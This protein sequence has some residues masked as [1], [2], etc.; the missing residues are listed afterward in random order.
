MKKSEFKYLDLTLYEDVLDNGLKVYIVPKNTVNNIYVTFTTKFGSNILEFMPFDSDKMIKVP[1]GIAHFLEHKTFEQKDGVDPFTFYTKNGADA[2]AYTNSKQTTYLFSGAD[3]FS[4]NLNYLLDYVQA[5]YYTDENV[6]KEKGIIEQELKMYE[7]NPYRSM[8]HDICKN[9][10]TTYSFQTPTIGTLE[11]IYS[12]TKEDLYKCYNTFYNPSNM[13]IVITG[14]VDP[15]ATIEIIKENQKNKVFK[16]NNSKIKVKYE[17][18]KDEVSKTYEECEKNI[19]IPNVLI[20]Y[21]FNKKLF[22]KVK[23]NLQYTVL[24]S[25]VNSV[26]GID[27]KF[28]EK[29]LDKKLINNSLDIDIYITRDH[30]TLVIGAETEHINEII[31]YVRKEINKKQLNEKMFNLRKKS[32]LSSLIYGSDNIFSINR[33][34]MGDIIDNDSVNINE[35]DDIKALSFSDYKDIIENITFENESILICNPKK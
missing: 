3:N 34:I 11:D 23:D 1:S 9:V 18:E 13:F 2:N 29:M 27:S 7:D 31:K 28:Y 33:S 22:S 16:N 15:A 14:N 6:E 17:K 30:F 5:P 35:Y 12:I 25:Y 10:Y 19:T 20:A 26:L 4:E 32:T 24:S 8:Y 21:K